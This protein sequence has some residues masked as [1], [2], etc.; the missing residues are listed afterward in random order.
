M[1]TTAE[2]SRHFAHLRSLHRI[3]PGETVPRP[4]SRPVRSRHARITAH[5]GRHHRQ[6]IDNRLQ[7]DRTGRLK[8][9]DEQEIA[10]ASVP[11]HRAIAEPHDMIQDAKILSPAHACG[12]PLVGSVGPTTNNRACGN[13]Q[14]V[15]NAVQALVWGCMQID[16]QI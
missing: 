16:S 13:T 11:G 6:S 15:D 1:S 12:G 7:Y 4:Q 5:R 8:R 14:G 3:G 2:G 9:A 10:A